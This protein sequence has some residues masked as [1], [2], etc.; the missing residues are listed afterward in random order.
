MRYP[1]RKALGCQCILDSL[2][3]VFDGGVFNLAFQMM[4]LTVGHASFHALCGPTGK[5]SRLIGHRIL[6]RANV[7]FA[8]IPK[9]L[10]QML[11]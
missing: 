11:L 5:A 1:R 3:H 4:L 6:D 7:F 10:K 8:R 9:N 2:C